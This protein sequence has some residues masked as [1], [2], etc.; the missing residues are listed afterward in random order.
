MRCAPP[1]GTVPA[2]VWLAAL[3][4]L[5]TSASQAPEPELRFQVQDAHMRRP[6]S[7]V[8]ECAHRL[9]R[10]YLQRSPSFTEARLFDWWASWADIVD[11][12]FVTTLSTPSSECV[13]Q[14]EALLRDVGALLVQLLQLKRRHHALPDSTAAAVLHTV[15]NAGLAS[16][17]CRGVLA[18]YDSGSSA[19]QPLSADQLLLVLEAVAMVAASAKAVIWY[20][21]VA[22]LP[23]VLQPL[24]QQAVALIGKDLVALLK[25]MGSDGSC[26][27]LDPAA[28]LLQAATCSAA[29]AVTRMGGAVL[30]LMVEDE[31]CGG[32]MKGLCAAF[33]P[34]KA[35]LSVSA[36]LARAHGVLAPQAY[37][38]ALAS[39]AKLAQLAAGQAE[40][41]VLARGDCQ[42]ARMR[43]SETLYGLAAHSLAPPACQVWQPFASLQRS[44]QA[45]PHEPASKAICSTALPASPNHFAATYFRTVYCRNAGAQQDSLFVMGIRAVTILTEIPGIFFNN[46]F[47]STVNLLQFAA[48]L[49]AHSPLFHW[50]GGDRLLEAACAACS[51]RPPRQPCSQCRTQSQSQLG[52]ARDEALPRHL[53]SCCAFCLFGRCCHRACRNG[54]ARTYLVPCSAWRMKLSTCCLPRF[55]WTTGGT[56]LFYFVQCYNSRL[57]GAGA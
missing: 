55:R 38:C 15:I 13:Q 27:Y 18:A 32:L 21:L 52:T 3:R 41:P 22:E 53:L 50:L 54:M 11:L 37:D 28:P 56:A 26:M 23:A 57:Y 29:E 51:V 44:V 45:C 34:A 40:Q 49:S 6:L 35:L 36:Q 33:A 5:T 42:Y 30:R 43:L 2:G 17:L 1:A 7:L 48:L 9:V 25:G 12:I 19:A 46:M 10:Q 31:A 14:R 4:F 47:S 8:A 20:E 39:I 24:L 16:S